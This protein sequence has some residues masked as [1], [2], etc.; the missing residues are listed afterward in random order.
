MKV[1]T[2]PV[3]RNHSFTLYRLEFG[4]GFRRNFYKFRGLFVYVGK[5]ILLLII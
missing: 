2:V 1:D 5:I 3:A 4:F